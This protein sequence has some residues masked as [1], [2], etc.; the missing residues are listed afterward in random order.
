MDRGVAVDAGG[1]EMATLHPFRFGLRRPRSWRQHRSRCHPSIRSGTGF[2]SGEGGR[3]A[4][5]DGREAG[6]EARGK[7]VNG[8]VT[9]PG[10]TSAAVAAA[11][12][13]YWVCGRAAGQTL[14]LA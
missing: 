2:Y 4:G 5:G 11:L 6:R 10:E 7:A 3:E 8:K 1:I 9:A 14:S 13:F 12:V